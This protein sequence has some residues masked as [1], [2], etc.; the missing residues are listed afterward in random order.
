MV[1]IIKP[2]RFVVESA[3]ERFKRLTSFDKGLKGSRSCVVGVDEVGRGCLAGPVVAAAVI[4]PPMKPRSALAKALVELNDSKL[5]EP[6]KRER[7]AEAIRT[8]SIYAIEQAS[9]EEI[10]TINILNASLLAMKR[11]I[12]KLQEAGCHLLPEAIVA[13][14]GNKQISDISL[15]QVTV[16]RGDGQSASIAA[17]SVVAKVHRDALMLRLAEEFPHYHWHSNKGYG[18]PNH[19]RAIIE[20]G[21]CGWHRK[22]FVEN[23]LNP[24]VQLELPFGQSDEEFAL[25]MEE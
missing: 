25:A 15:S 20:H 6:E 8:S 22:V 21:I 9:V 14:D 16:I 24:V 1:P 2:P 12:L 18:S 11:A 3:Q 5:V 23:I 7:L 19:R 13:V 17:A 4:L 10:N